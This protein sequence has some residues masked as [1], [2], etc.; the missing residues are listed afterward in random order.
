[1]SRINYNCEDRK[2][3]TIMK[4]ITKIPGYRDAT[5]QECG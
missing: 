5:E 1:M 4:G 3:Q 2:T